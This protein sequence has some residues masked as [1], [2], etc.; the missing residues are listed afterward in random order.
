MDWSAR[1]LVFRCR[2]T[3]L[4]VK[5]VTENEDLVFV[6]CI[7]NTLREKQII[8]RKGT[9]EKIKD[10]SDSAGSWTN[11]DKRDRNEADKIEKIMD[12]ALIADGDAAHNGCKAETKLYGRGI[13]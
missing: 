2:R 13:R 5:C 11:E 3:F 8:I 7:F 10:G 6:T 9:L 12:A 1:Q 4:K